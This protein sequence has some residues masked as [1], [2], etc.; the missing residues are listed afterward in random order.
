MNQ[1]DSHGNTRITGYVDVTAYGLVSSSSAVTK[2][3]TFSELVIK[4]GIN[5]STGYAIAT[6]G[7]N[8]IAETYISCDGVELIFKIVVSRGAGAQSSGGYGEA[9]W[10]ITKI[11]QYY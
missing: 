3:T 2:R 8:T 7:A 9:K 4:N 1:T 11:E 5:M 6:T 10:V